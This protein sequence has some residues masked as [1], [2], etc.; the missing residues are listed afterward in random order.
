MAVADSAEVDVD[1]DAGASGP[2]AAVIG[3]DGPCSSRRAMPPMISAMAD[4]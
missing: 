4:M 3:A 1:G 2:A